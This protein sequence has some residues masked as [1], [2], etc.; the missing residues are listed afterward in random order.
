MTWAT[1]KVAQRGLHTAATCA[2][3]SRSSMAMNPMLGELSHGV[4]RRSAMLSDR[5]IGL[6][7]PG[8]LRAMS[9]D[10]DAVSHGVTT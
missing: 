10:R 9:H 2:I 1:T 5:H 4:M 8:R 3:K 7:D 6:S